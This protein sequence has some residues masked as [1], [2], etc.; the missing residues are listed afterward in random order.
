M[1]HKKQAGLK[2]VKAEYNSGG[3][4]HLPDLPVLLVF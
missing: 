4:R 1:C 3:C 2:R